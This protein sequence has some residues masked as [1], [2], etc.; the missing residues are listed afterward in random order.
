MTLSRMSLFR[1]PHHKGTGQNRRIDGFGFK[2]CWAREFAST[3][4]EIQL[5]LISAANAYVQGLRWELCLQIDLNLQIFKLAKETRLDMA[6]NTACNSIKEAEEERACLFVLLL[7]T[8]FWL[9][10]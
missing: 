6:P 5:Q 2:W 1:P 9:V 10:L 3:N 4:L 7:R 8:S